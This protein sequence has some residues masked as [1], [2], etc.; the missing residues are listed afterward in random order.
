MIELE[1]LPVHL[2]T[3]NPNDWNNLFMLLPEIENTNDFGQVQG[4]EKLIDGSITMPYWASTKIVDDVFQTIMDLNICP[5]FDWPDWEDG[6]Q[7][8]SNKTFDYSKI[9]AVT[10]CKLLTVIIRTDKFCDGHLISCFQD[11]TMTKIITSLKN[12]I[13][14]GGS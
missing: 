9:D 14:N 10:L 8:L 6:R 4:G 1:Q 3:L 5:I 11:G 7:I 12:K 2:Q 13:I